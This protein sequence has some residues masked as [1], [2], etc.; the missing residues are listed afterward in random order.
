MIK[1]FFLFFCLILSLNILAFEVSPFNPNVVDD[2]STLNAESIERINITITQLRSESDVWAAVYLIHDLKGNNLEDVAEEVF[3]KWKLGKEGKDNGLLILLSIN[4]RETRIEVGYGL[5]GEITDFFAHQVIQTIMIPAFKENRFADGIDLALKEIN[6]KMK[7]SSQIV[8][9]GKIPNEEEDWDE[10]LLRL[11]YWLALL[12]LVPTF[13]VLGSLA[14]AVVVQPEA[15]KKMK[16]K[17]RIN[18]VHC[19]T[20]VNSSIALF[21]KLFFTINPGVFIVIFPVMVAPNDPWV[22]WLFDGLGLICVAVFIMQPVH[23]MRRLFSMDYFMRSEALKRLDD[24]RKTLSPGKTYTMFGKS[25]T[26]PTRSSGSSYSSSGSSRSS[27]SGGG[28]SGGGGASGR[29]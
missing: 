8:S 5:E 23:F 6:L 4:D 25:Y 14:T 3:R 7:D 13:I 21:L 22:G 20:G 19:L 15:F 28:R 9:V 27:S 26:A 11:K 18:P 10:V 2:T 17:K 1:S 16:E 12:W 29:W 24:H